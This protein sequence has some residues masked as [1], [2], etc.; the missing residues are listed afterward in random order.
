MGEACYAGGMSSS[1][2]PFFPSETS[3]LTLKPESRLPVERGNQLLV[4]ETALQT[5]TL[6]LDLMTR[7]ALWGK[8]F[9]IAGDEWLPDRDSF[10]RALRRH[11]V[12][13]DEALNRPTLMRPMTCLQMTDLLADPNLSRQPILVVNFFYHFYDADVDL[14]LRERTLDQCCLKLRQLAWQTPVTVLVPRLNCW[15]YKRF[16]PVLAGLAD[17]ILSVSEPIPGLNIQPELF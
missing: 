2:P 1:N 11:T 6:L 7:L 9:L 3:S 8:Y 17:E 14:R 15:E 13:V 4:V 5:Q 10:Y 12:R 16:F